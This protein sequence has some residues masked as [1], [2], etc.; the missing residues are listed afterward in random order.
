MHLKP[1]SDHLALKNSKK[2]C[3]LDLGSILRKSSLELGYVQIQ[4]DLLLEIVDKLSDIS[5]IQYLVSKVYLG[6]KIKQKTIPLI[7]KLTLMS[8]GAKFIDNHYFFN[9]NLYLCGSNY[10]NLAF[11]L[12]LNNLSTANLDQI[13][14]LSILSLHFIGISSSEKVHLLIS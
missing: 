9:N 12:F 2:S 10:A 1:N 4:D 11:E 7:M 3:P 8:Y 6:M 14:S 13:F 5:W